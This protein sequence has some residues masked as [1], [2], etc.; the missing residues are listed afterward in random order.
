MAREIPPAFSARTAPLCTLRAPLWRHVRAPVLY[1]LPDC[2]PS[3]P[4]RRADSRSAWLRRSFPAVPSRPREC[5][6]GS[7]VTPAGCAVDPKAPALAS[8]A[9][10]GESAQERPV[11]RAEPPPA[12]N[13]AASRSFSG[14]R[15][16]KIN[17]PEVKIGRNQFDS[18]IPAVRPLHSL[19]NHQAIR[20]LLGHEVGD[21]QTLA[22]L[23]LPGAR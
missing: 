10:L 2:G 13:S 5:W 1:Q 23:D 9:P 7:A 20:G 17:P 22:H 4:W 8:K 3:R 15:S 12:A 19:P 21:P 14:R 6:R 18:N 11:F 16:S